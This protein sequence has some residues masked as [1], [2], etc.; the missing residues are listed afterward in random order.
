[1]LEEMDAIEQAVAN[2]YQR[3]PHLYHGAKRLWK[4]A[5]LQQHELLVLRT[6]Y[7]RQAARVEDK[8]AAVKAELA[9]L[10]DPLMEFKQFD[11]MYRSIRQK[12]SAD[13]YEDVN[14]LYA[15][16]SSAPASEIKKVKGRLK[17]KRKHILSLAAAHIDV[18]TMFSDE[19]YYGKYVDLRSFHIQYKTLVGD[20]TY[21]EYL[22]KFAEL[23]CGHGKEYEAY[24]AEL[25]KYL[26]G[27]WARARPLEAK[28]KV[29]ASED[30][31]FCVPCQKRFAKQSVFDGHLTGK[32]H[33][34]FAARDQVTENP[35]RVH[36][37]YIQA[38]AKAL[39]AVIEDTLANHER[40]S[41]LTDRERMLE[42]ITT[43]GDESDYTDME[44][45]AEVSSDESDDESNLPIGPDGKP[46]PFWLYK[47]QGLNHSYECE[48]CGGALFQGRV[49]FNK[50]FGSAKHQYGLKCLGVA[51][52]SMPLFE[53]ITK[54]DEAKSLWKQL[55]RQLRKLETAAEGAVEVE[56][57]E[58]NVMTE[59]DYLD[60]KRQG[61]L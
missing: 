3:Y 21:K 29:E 11:E 61:L 48:I 46:V 16:Y 45:A 43:F 17:V 9:K 19:E 31:L 60:L 15:M 1:M 32:K 23:P 52:E 22:G 12:N 25:H 26:E 5:L 4:E 36:E 57:D 14:Q 18:S 55:K 49:M 50:H 33:K 54:I 24:V 7:E 40:R 53:N 20:I 58:G 30:P 27:F 47:L 35:V 6:T 41:V 10:A 42:D 44:L 37:K 56:D 8:K 28:P 2:R 13:A 38:Y 34:K 59:K 51:E 39:V